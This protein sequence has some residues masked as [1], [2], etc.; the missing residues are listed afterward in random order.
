MYCNYRRFAIGKLEDIC[1]FAV[2]E[3]EKRGAEYTEVYMA[4]NKESEVFI[5]NNDLK[6]SKS[7]KSSGL[8][9]R[10]FVRG[11]VGFS[12]V[13]ILEREHIKNAVIQA[14]KL[15][16]V[17][18]TDKFNSMPDK[19]EI[20]F[21]KS[22]YDRKAESFNSSDA[23]KMASDMLVAA[24]SFDDRVSVDSGNFTSSV[25]THA[26]LNSNGIRANE[27]ISSFSWSL[28]GM[29][30]NGKEISNF[31]F[32][33]GATHHVKNIDVLSTAGNLLKQL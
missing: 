21:L 2:R 18:P 27:T 19:T 7:H 31:D 33:F 29:A 20:K 9:I 22:I 5:E 24:K 14:I 11:S 6:Q 23:T 25:M 16:R 3:A 32:Q 13:N 4:R 12:S 28:M 30:I 8:G 17:T 15:A 10:V 1:S 26:L